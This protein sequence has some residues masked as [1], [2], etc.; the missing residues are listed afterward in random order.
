MI[1][2]PLNTQKGSS[3]LMLADSFKTTAI[4]LVAFVLVV[5][6]RRQLDAYAIPADILN[7]LNIATVFMVCFLIVIIARA[8][9]PRRR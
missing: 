3:S 9:I 5:V 8:W 6:M 2:E 1:G 7:V 4:G